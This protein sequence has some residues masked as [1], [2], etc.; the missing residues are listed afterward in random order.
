MIIIQG[1][2]VY[3]K[4]LTKPKVVSAVASPST[5]AKSIDATNYTVSASPASVLDA[6]DSPTA[7]SFGGDTKALLLKIA[8]AD[9]AKEDGTSTRSRALS[10][11]RM[12][13]LPPT[14]EEDATP[15]QDEARPDEEEVE[16]EQELDDPEV[17]FSALDEH[18]IVNG[19]KVMF[20]ENHGRE[21]TVDEAEKWL[22]A[23]REAKTSK[24]AEEKAEEN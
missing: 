16:G 19:L 2:E 18:D 12:P 17:D 22:E 9:A 23:I 11:V 3:S 13:P 10:P 6:P 15:A 14:H 5:P 21:A 20:R 24:A 1:F 7:S 4:P 8:E